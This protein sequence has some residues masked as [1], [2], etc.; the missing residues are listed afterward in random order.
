MATPEHT[1]VPGVRVGAGLVTKAQHSGT[2]LGAAV[3]L[4]G[5]DTR[6]HSTALHRESIP[7]CANQQTLSEAVG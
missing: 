2:R 3:W 6:L 1:G 7:L 4:C 5:R